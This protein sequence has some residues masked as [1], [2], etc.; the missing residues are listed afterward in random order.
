MRRF[1]HIVSAF[2]LVALLALASL[3]ISSQFEEEVST[4]P[5]VPVSSTNVWDFSSAL[6]LAKGITSGEHEIVLFS[7]DGYRIDAVL[8]ES[9]N[10]EVT[11]SPEPCDD[12]V[13]GYGA[14]GIPIYAHQT[15]SVSLR[16]DMEGNGWIGYIFYNSSSF[17]WRDLELGFESV[18]LANISDA[19]TQEISNMQDLQKVDKILFES[20]WRDQIHLNNTEI[21]ISLAYTDGVFLRITIIEGKFFLEVSYFSE[22]YSNYQGTWFKDSGRERAYYVAELTAFFPNYVKAVNEFI[23][24]IL[25]D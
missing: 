17:G 6:T 8:G 4:P 5:L 10:I 20:L 15:Q 11:C 14:Y 2:L 12:P 21:E 13:F 24:L 22:Y 19:L 16:Q 23:G 9:T 7:T 18:N 3:G 25:E 1:K